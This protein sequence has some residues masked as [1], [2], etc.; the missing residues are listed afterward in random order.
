MKNITKTPVLIGLGIIVLLIVGATAVVLLRYNNTPNNTADTPPN[1][2]SATEKAQ[3]LENEA[4]ELL[5]SDPSKAQEKFMEAKKLYEEAG[6]SN[7]ASE[8]E[9]SADSAQAV[10]D[11]QEMTKKQAKDPDTDDKAKGTSGHTE[12]EE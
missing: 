11:F 8:A 2:P 5:D 4:R 3:G 6:D 7:K 10:K 1:T 9:A 12:T